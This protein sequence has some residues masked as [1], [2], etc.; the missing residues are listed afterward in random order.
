MIVG[1][2][3]SVAYSHT[4]GKILAFAFLKPHVAV[5]NIEITVI[6]AGKPRKGRTGSCG[7]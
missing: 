5:Q 3:A 2:S 7:L 1:S 4:Y 6:V